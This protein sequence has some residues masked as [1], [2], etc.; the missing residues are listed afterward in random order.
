MAP[1]LGG[2]A[3]YFGEAPNLGSMNA[4][5]APHSVTAALVLSLVV[6]SAV[7][8]TAFLLG[9]ARGR[10][11]DVDVFWPLGFLAIAGATWLYQTRPY[12]ASALAVLVIILAWSLRLGG[13]LAWR[14]RG[15][16]EDARYAALIGDR[17]GAARITRLITVVYGLQGIIMVIV[18]S[19]LVVA[20]SENTAFTPQLLIGAFLSVLGIGL[21]FLADA[22]LAHFR[23]Q[24]RQGVM[25]TGLWAHSRH[26]NYLGE[27]LV[28][29]GLFFIAAS[30]WQGLL[31]IV[32]P[33]TMTWLLI[34]VSG[35]ELLERHLIEVKPGYHDYVERVP[36][37]MPSWRRR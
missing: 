5:I 19:P 20:I 17:R 26:P 6:A 15:E 29:W 11:R 8:A 22:Q 9:L 34:K 31:T 28:W 32:S 24:N 3:L 25:Q 37:L 27:I 1:S 10:V 21:E 36:G 4:T 13:Y 12:H 14:S 30:T 23:K 7:M 18:A 33:I 16:P 35:K 2:V